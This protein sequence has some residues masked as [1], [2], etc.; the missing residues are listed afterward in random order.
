MR[1]PPAVHLDFVAKPRGSP[2]AAAL[3]CVLG[4]AGAAAMGRAFQRTLAE[5]E[6]LEA[7]LAATVQPRHARPTAAPEALAEAAAVQHELGLGWTRL[8]AELESASHDGAGTISLLHVE[9]DAAKQVVRITAEVR[10]LQDALAWLRRLQKSPLLRY[11]MLE[12]HERRKD[13]AEHP[14]LVKLTA[15]WRT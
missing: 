8:L 6:R 14:I 3:L 1:K 15:E 9:P 5:R 10:T 4:I 12:T 7:K 11:P 13:D 2:V